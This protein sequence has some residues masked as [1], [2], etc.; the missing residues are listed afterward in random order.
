LIQTIKYTEKLSLF[1]SALRHKL[2]FNPTL[3]HSL[4]IR[5]YLN[6]TLN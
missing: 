6:I 2:A 5:L 1:N 3:Q 4:K